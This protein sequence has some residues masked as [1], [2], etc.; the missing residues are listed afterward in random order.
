MDR[1]SLLRWLLIGAAIF[2]FVQYGL[3]QI[4]GS[5]GKGSEKQPLGHI[6]DATAPT[7]RADEVM[8]DVAGERFTAQLSSRGATLRH[9]RMTDDKYTAVPGGSEPIELATT[10]REARMP[11][12]TDLRTAG[13]W[14]DGKVEWP[15]GTAAQVPYNDLDYKLVASDGTRCR[16]TY[17]DERVTIDKTVAATGRPFEL[18][19]SVTVTNKD[20]I[21][22]SHRFTIE[23]TEW[24]TAKETAGSWGRV[25]EF[26]THSEASAG[27]ETLRRLPGDFEADDFDDQDAGFTEDG[28]RREKGD[29]RWAAVSSSY[30]SKAVF[31][32]DGPS[33]PSAELLVEEWWRTQAY[34]KKTDDPEY[35]HVY[36]A[37]L[38]Y[39]A[40]ELASG[41]SA[42]YKLLA[43]VGPK[44]R[45]VLA[46]V[47]GS[48]ELDATQLLDLGTFGAI[49]KVLIQ[50]LYILFGLVGTWGI[51][52]CLLTITVKLLLFPLSIAQIKS[53]MA[54]RKLKPQ[55]DE[56]NEKYK[57]DAGQRGVAMQELWRKNN[58]SN[59]MLG[60]LPVLLQ[61]PVWF[62]LYTSLQTAVELYHTPFGFFI[63]DLSAPG[64]F[65]VIP[66][67]L[68]ASSYL[69]Q[70]LMPMQGD[71]LQQKMM[72]YMMPGVFTVMMLFLPAGLGI[73][74]LTN[75]WLGIGQQLAVERYYKSRADGDPGQPDDQR[76]D[77]AKDA[78]SKGK[79]GS[80]KS[81]SK[82]VEPAAFNA[83]GPKGPAAA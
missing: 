28:W 16:F 69:Q 50:Y 14:K 31:H 80:S 53:T 57:D 40:R 61:M 55:M 33:K 12:R 66:I 44:E 60:C 49:G 83:A 25:S 6:A 59:P 38:N 70:H 10:T 17:D 63:P 41:E 21:A 32:L 8:C 39:G 72:K 81:S 64:L 51:A 37:R 1:S 24:R 29:A 71:P 62:A 20:K 35:G 54:M 52:I 15:E 9:I 58:V 76:A 56:I 45:D 75:T 73:Y 36:R 78:K 11:L 13:R 23:Q 5:N 26:M 2:L 22:Q 47:G 68:G 82:R 67:L 30:F 34:A 3:P 18:D 4:T 7:D 27:G 46:H 48:S 74:F 65:Y 19:V 77:D 79:R 42:S 43:Y